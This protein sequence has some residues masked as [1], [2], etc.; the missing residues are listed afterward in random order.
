MEVPKT[1]QAPSNWQDFETLCKRIWGEIWHSN[2]IKKNGRTGQQQAGVDI[3]DAPDCESGVVGI[4][5]KC[6]NTPGKNQLTESEIEEEIAAASNFRPGLSK[7]YIMST[8]LKDTG[9]EA[10]VMTKDLEHR[11]KGLFRISLFCWD[12]II[13]LLN[14]KA[15]DTLQSYLKGMNAKTADSVAITFENRKNSDTLFPVF[16]RKVRYKIN[17]E[18]FDGLS[19]GVGAHL[20]TM[21]AWSELWAPLQA[22]RTKRNLSFVPVQILL[23]NTGNRSIEEYKVSVQISGIIFEI[24]DNNVEY[25]Y[26]K[27]IFPEFNS[28]T[29]NSSNRT[30]LII[31]KILVPGDEF[32]AGPIFIK[33]T[34]ETGKITFEWQLLSKHFSDSG[35]LTLDISPIFKRKVETIIDDELLQ[36]QTEHLGYEDYIELV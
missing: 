12:D 24:S 25:A 27:I 31:N 36:P 18:Q 16:Y 8:A 20:D 17:Q 14:E 22:N 23:K 28:V 6:K 13:D 10:F 35:T 30:V 32:K 7:Y 26:N 11:S 34:Y 29:L 4:Q 1:L 2:E 15:P 5:C 3:Y 33:P 19:G 9:I 21:K